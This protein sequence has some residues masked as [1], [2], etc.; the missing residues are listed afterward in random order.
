MAG[1][2]TEYVS[3]TIYAAS[4]HG[5][6]APKALAGGATTYRSDAGNEGPYWAQLYARL[7]QATGDM[8]AWCHY[9]FDAC[10]APPITEIDESKYFSPKPAAANVAP[11]PSGDTINVLHLSDWHIDP[12]YDIGSESNCTDYLW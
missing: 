1:N 11:T 6:F 12:R 5:E 9:H 3:D 2:K 8:Q 4:C 7:S 10:D